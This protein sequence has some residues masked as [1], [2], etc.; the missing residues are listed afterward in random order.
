M[1]T[2]LTVILQDERY[3]PHLPRD[4]VTCS[5]PRS[6]EVAVGRE[7][8]RLLDSVLSC[9]SPRP[10][11]FLECRSDFPLVFY[12]SFCLTFIHAALQHSM[13]LLVA[14]GRNKNNCDDWIQTCSSPVFCS[15]VWY[16]PSSFRFSPFKL[17]L[18]DSIYF[19]A[20]LALPLP[21]S[22]ILGQS[23]PLGAAIFSPVRRDE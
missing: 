13:T 7:S 16:P 3:Y 2:V 8:R 18:V 23:C 11:P 20:T 6:P 12:M 14:G 10:L 1:P 21:R 19:S 15:P 17:L 4:E 9:S 5:T 22:M